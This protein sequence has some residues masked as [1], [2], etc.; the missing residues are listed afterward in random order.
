VSLDV[1]T[2]PEPTSA[3]L[4]ISGLAAIALLTWSQNRS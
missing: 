1:V 3:L 4:L 2:V